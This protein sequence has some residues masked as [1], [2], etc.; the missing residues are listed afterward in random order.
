[1]IPGAVVVVIVQSVPITTDVLSSNPAQ[2][3]VYNIICDKV[4]Q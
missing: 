2:C 1:M 3:E 4:C